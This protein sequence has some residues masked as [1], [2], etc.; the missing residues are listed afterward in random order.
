[1]SLV[2]PTFPAMFRKHNMSLLFTDSPAP[3]GTSLNNDVIS[4]NGDFYHVFKNHNYSLHCVVL[5]FL[6]CFLI[7][8]EQPVRQ[9][10]WFFDTQTRTLHFYNRRTQYIF[11]LNL[12]RNSLRKPPQLNKLVLNIRTVIF[13]TL[14]QLQ[15][16]QTNSTRINPPTEI[17]HHE[18]V[19]ITPHPLLTSLGKVNTRSSVG[20]SNLH[21]HITFERHKFGNKIS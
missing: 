10:S 17:V 1:V 21:Q 7:L 8:S 4:L 13:N 6:F 2:C 5:N 11:I 18:H 19:C 16:S 20:L 12:Q 14:N 9:T 15:Q 3:N